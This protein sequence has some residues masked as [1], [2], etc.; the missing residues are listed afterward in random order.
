VSGHEIPE[1]LAARQVD[2]C[3]R[4]FVTRF[5]PLVAGCPHSAVDAPVFGGNALTIAARDAF[6]T[7]ALISVL[8][9]TQIM[10][11]GRYKPLP[12]PVLVDAESLEQAHG[13]LGAPKGTLFRAVR[14][15]EAEE[16][17]QRLAS[18]PRGAEQQLCKGLGLLRSAY[19]NWSEN[20]LREATEIVRP[21]RPSIPGSTVEEPDETKWERARWDYSSLISNALE[22]VLLVSWWTEGK[23]RLLSPAMYCADWTA[24]S[25]A[26][27]WMGGIRVCAYCKEPFVP[28]TEKQTDYCCLKHGAAQRTARSR[29][30]HG[31]TPAKPKPAQSRI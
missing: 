5:L 27:L 24:A 6:G 22:R 28:K 23:E 8:R 2:P 31:N 18:D 1:M 30:K 16:I 15:V 20:S 17:R 12:I 25:F 7:V 19:E 21:W 26:A 11:I 9:F 4:A 3:W 13:W 29:K 14:T 10:R